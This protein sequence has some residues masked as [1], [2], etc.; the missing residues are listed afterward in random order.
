M[1]ITWIVN[2][3]ATAGVLLSAPL[4][5]RFAQFCWLYFVRPS[6]IHRYL[7]GPSPYALVTG[8][9][10]GIGKAIAQELYS[11]GFN[12]L[13]HG[14]SEQKLHKVVDEIISQCPQGRQDVRFF[15]ADVAVEEHK[16]AELLEPHKHL[17]ITVVIHNVGG[18]IFRPERIDGF[19]EDELIN[20]IYRNAVFPLLLTRALLN[21]LRGS[22][23]HGP[24]MVQFIGSR[25]ADMSAPF[26]ALYSAAKRSL[27]ALAMGLDA[28][29][30]VYDGPSHV[31]FVYLDVGV[32]QSNTMRVPNSLFSPSAKR[33][34]RALV[35][36][37]GYEGRRYA[38]WM[39][40]A[41]MQWVAEIGGERATT[42]IYG[43]DAIL[44]HLSARDKK[45]S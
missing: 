43:T 3:A 10:D 45:L 15:L 14:R 37:V 30:R 31:R 36:K 2:V 9:S 29:E 17:N 39:P 12:L 21:Q 25:A 13:L 32:V 1:S 33:F 8:A 41:A 24:I 7:H 42:R 22:A 28:D 16:F 20:V 40:H 34:A 19:G 26:F 35:N 11:Q 6:S 44:S 38:P 5:Y 23:K 18:S 4:V 27:Q